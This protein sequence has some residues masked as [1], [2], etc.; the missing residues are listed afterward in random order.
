MAELKLFIKS[1]WKCLLTSLLSPGLPTKKGIGLSCTSSELNVLP[2][3]SP[4]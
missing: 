4:L 3:T 1:P 2:E